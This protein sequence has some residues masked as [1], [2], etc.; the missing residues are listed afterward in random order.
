M[1]AVVMLATK[2][3]SVCVLTNRVFTHIDYVF[4]RRDWVKRVLKFS[5]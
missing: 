5:S 4:V 3:H 1:L 2:N